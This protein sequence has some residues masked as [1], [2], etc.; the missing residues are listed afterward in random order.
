M[1]TMRTLLSEMSPD[2]REALLARSHRVDF[3]SGTRIFDE[4]RCA[5]RFW[6]IENGTVELDM[7]VPGHKAAVVE[8]LGFGDLLGWSWMVP[9][10]LW[11]LGATATHPV[12]A[13][14][15]DAQAVRELCAEDSG[16]GREVSIGVAAVIARRLS[17][18]RNRLLAMFASNGS[19][20]LLEDSR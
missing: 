12:Q 8:T 13:L 6:I 1:T 7:H 17:A 11:H 16:V 19:G 18:S 10:Y 5:D 3:P 14:E 9:P 4:H 15:F 2:A 20:Q